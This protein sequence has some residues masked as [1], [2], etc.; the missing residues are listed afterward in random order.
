[1]GSSIQRTIILIVLLINVSHAKNFELAAEAFAE[2]ISQNISNLLYVAGAIEPCTK[3][4]LSHE[5]KIIIDKQKKLRQ[6]LREKGGEI[7][8][9]RCRSEID[10]KNYLD[11][12]SIMANRQFI[13]LPYF[14]RIQFI[15]SIENY[16]ANLKYKIADSLTLTLVETKNLQTPLATK[17]LDRIQ[18]RLDHDIDFRIRYYNKDPDFETGAL[19]YPDQNRIDLNLNL[20]I[21]S[22]TE[23]ANSFEHEFWHHLVS[24]QLQGLESGNFWIEGFTECISEIWSGHLNYKKTKSSPSHGTIYYPVQTAFASLYLGVSRNLTIS[25][26]LAIIDQ[27]EFLNRFVTSKVPNHENENLTLKNAEA[28]NHSDPSFR[29]ILASLFRNSTNI[30]AS[31]QA[32]IEKILDSWGWRE[33]DGS[34]VKINRFVRDG[35]L[36]GQSL[37]RSFFSEKQF[38]T[39]VIRALTIANLYILFDK[40]PDRSIYQNLPLPDHLIKN[41]YRISKYVNE[42]N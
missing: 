28:S 25:Y 23:F 17:V 40:F 13:E 42:F 14:S 16:F 22:P 3:L 34:D 9:S 41:I 10:K 36:D 20:M 30:T 11:F 6:W 15:Q 29:K 2:K 31:R 24:P 33:D 26:L 19:Y 21:D 38:A 39:D 32:K 1:M 37:S 27:D 5:R 12:Q 7:D 8:I 35:K 4:E 18:L